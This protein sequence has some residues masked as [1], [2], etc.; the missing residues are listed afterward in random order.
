MLTWLSV[1]HVQ[2]EVASCARG[3]GRGC[4]QGNRAGR[5]DA[6]HPAGLRPTCITPLHII[7]K[8]FGMTLRKMLALAP[9]ARLCKTQSLEQATASLEAARAREQELVGLSNQVGLEPHAVM[10]SALHP[11]MNRHWP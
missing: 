2:A 4:H 1:A 5:A 3:Q 9:E 8:M 7:F 11:P 6:A 10:P